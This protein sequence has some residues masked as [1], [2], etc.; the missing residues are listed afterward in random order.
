[1]LEALKLKDTPQPVVT[2]PVETPTEIL[3]PGYEYLNEDERK[4]LVAYTDTITKKAQEAI[5]KDPA[6]AFARNSYNENKWEQAFNAVSTQHPELKNSKDEF[7]SKYFK[8]NNVPDNIENLLGDIAKIYLFDKAKN[9]GAEEER[10]KINR[11]ETERNTGGDRTP[12]TSRSL[13][14]WNRMAQENPAKFA[15]M[16]KEYNAD[17]STGKI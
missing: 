15:S 3:Y 9:I 2:P 7:K 12:T 5:Y 16:S 6:I 13:E 14:D 17:I 4:N 8:A 10:A 1:L 11:I